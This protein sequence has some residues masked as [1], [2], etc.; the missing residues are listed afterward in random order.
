[1]WECHTDFFIHTKPQKVHHIKITFGKTLEEYTP[2]EATLIIKAQFYIRK[3]YKEDNLMYFLQ[4]Q[5][6]NDTLLVIIKYR[7]KIELMNFQLFKNCNHNLC[8]HTYFLYFSIFSV[9]MVNMSVH[10]YIKEYILINFQCVCTL[11]FLI[12]EFFLI[13]ATHWIDFLN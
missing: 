11:N 1:M 4:N 2:K 3:H 12:L 9:Y 8:V 6:I 7:N 5:D 13:V 10:I